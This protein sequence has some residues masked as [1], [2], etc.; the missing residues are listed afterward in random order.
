[1]SESW[2]VRLAVDNQRALGRLRRIPGLE[3]LQQNNWL[4][5]RGGALD[6]KLDKAIRSIPGATRLR[7][8]PDGQLV[9]D[10]RLVP[11]GYLPQGPWTGLAQWLAPELP[12]PALS[13][14]INQRVPVRLVR[15]RWLADPNVLMTSSQLWQDYAVWAPQV[16]LDRWAFAVGPRSDVVVRGE[17]LPPIKGR[18]FVERHGVAVAA[19]WTWTPPVEAA[20]L[21]QALKLREG[22]LALLHADAEWDFVRGDDFVRASRSAVRRSAVQREDGGMPAGDR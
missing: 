8:L 5:L 19:G 3:V 16:R 12:T 14:R 17:P 21:S 2:A 1:V 9:P 20:V 22:D 7:V 18:R 10:G 13:G 6:H 15:S 4:W 11:S